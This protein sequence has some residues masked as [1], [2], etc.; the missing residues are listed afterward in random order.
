MSNIPSKKKKFG[1]YPYEIKKMF[2]LSKFKKYPV[3]IH[4]SAS[5]AN[6]KYYS[7]FDLYSNIT[8]KYNTKE[9]YDELIKI[10]KKIDKSNDHYLIEIKVQQKDG[11][12]KRFFATDEFT[13]NEFEKVF[14]E[15][16]KMIKFDF[17]IYFNQKFI[18]VDIAYMF[19]VKDDK[20]EQDDKKDELK[21]EFERRI[22][23]KEYYK[24][25]KRLSSYYASQN[26]K[27]NYLKTVDFLNSPLG[28]LY[29]NKANLEAI[30]LVDKYYHSENLQK[31]INNNLKKLGYDENLNIKKEIKNLED[32]LNKEAK[33]FIKDL[34]KP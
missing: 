8:K 15:N 28:K 4:G 6:L 3:Q 16:T 26:D 14:N 11:E 5:R 17:I 9:I 34:P 19:N 21:E 27:K 20:D 12:K 18:V 1:E 32:T 23:D 2:Q 33:Q 24:S 22:K 13:F 7:D 31:K 29:E 10:I 30:E 25:V